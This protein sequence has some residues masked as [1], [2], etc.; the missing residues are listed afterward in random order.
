MKQSILLMDNKLA[1]NA[2]RRA[3][4]SIDSGGAHMCV[5]NSLFGSERQNLVTIGGNGD[6]MLPLSR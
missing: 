5:L 1:A 6:R 4:L 2:A 3:V